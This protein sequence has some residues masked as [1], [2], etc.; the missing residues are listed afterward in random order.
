MRGGIMLPVV[1]VVLSATLCAGA[2]SVQAGQQA[3]KAGPKSEFVGSE[4]CRK[5]HKIEYDSWKKTFHSKIVMPRKG[6]ILKE[7]VEKWAGD[8]A[9]PGPTV[10]T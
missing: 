9:N 3:K 7:A 1:G 10:G 4:Q 6:G 8:D 2:G 5:C